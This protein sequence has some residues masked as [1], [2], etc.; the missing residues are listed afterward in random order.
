MIGYRDPKHAV[1]LHEHISAF[2]TEIPIPGLPKTI[3]IL[4]KSARDV[5]LIFLDVVSAFNKYEGDPSERPGE[6]EMARQGTLMMNKVYAGKEAEW[7]RFDVQIA[8]LESTISRFERE[9]ELIKAGK[10]WDT[11]AQKEMLRVEKDRTE[12]VIQGMMRKEREKCD[13]IGC[14]CVEKERLG[15]LIMPGLGTRQRDLVDRKKIVEILEGR[16]PW[17]EMNSDAWFEEFKEQHLRM[18]GRARRE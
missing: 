13:A 10:K 3:E 14:T 18:N 8:S 12:S 6:R 2:P 1:Q 9:I 7:K 5:L 15:N 16:E 11:E 17:K 4:T